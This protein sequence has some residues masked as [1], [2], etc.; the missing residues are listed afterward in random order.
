MLK[1]V[2]KHIVL[3]RLRQYSRVFPTHPSPAQC[4][5]QSIAHFPLDATLRLPFPCGCEFHLPS[6]QSIALIW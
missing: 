2:L 4:S 1:P 6:P 3:A 5:P